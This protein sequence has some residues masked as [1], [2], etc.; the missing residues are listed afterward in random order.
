METLSHS[1]NFCVT[2]VDEQ[3]DIFDENEI[4]TLLRKTY[5]GEVNSFA[6]DFAYYIKVAKKLTDGMYNGFGSDL[7]KADFLTP[8][9]NMLKA[10]R[11][12]VYTFSAAKNFQQ[13]KLMS[14]LIIEGDNVLT[15]PD[16]K[17]KAEKVFTTFNR[18]HLT[19]EYN[20]AIS[21]GRM[22]SRWIDIKDEEPILGKLE[23]DTVGDAR[24]RPEHALLD[25]IVRPVGDTFWS[26]F[27][28]PNGW[29]CRC[30]V[31]QLDD[32]PITS[33]KTRQ[34]PDEKDVPKEF[35]FN[36][37]KTKRVYSA[38]HPYYKVQA[39]EAEFKKTNFGL[40]LP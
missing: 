33:L 1:C 23:Y 13:T 8:D 16:F 40:P 9:Y 11:E 27:Y 19:A 29:N 28:P 15:Y 26:T 10:L 6:L 37:G 12:N 35:R 20:S 38:E 5:T 34:R 18:Q 7:V 21:Q 25:G 22:A 30:D 4:E 14:S 32:K 3:L 24:V 2:N 17:K 39:N 36:V 31:I